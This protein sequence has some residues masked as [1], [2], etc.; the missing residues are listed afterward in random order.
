MKR[1][2]ERE[3]QINFIGSWIISNDKLFKNLIN[4]FEDNPQLHRQGVMGGGRN[5]NLDKKKTTEISIDPINLED[6]T[7]SIFYEYFNELFACYNDYKNQWPFL[8]E[9]LPVVDIP[10]FNLQRYLAGDHFSQV[11][12]ERISKS[13]MHRVFAWMTYL[14]DL[15]SNANGYTNFTHYDLKIKPLKGKTLIWPAEWT[16][17][18]AGETL[19]KGRKYIITGWFCFPFD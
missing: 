16:H 3:G 2:N 4:Y 10:S 18:H 5:I 9:K 6:K 15:E 11:H 17:A 7:H 8:K 19:I 12:T 13:N 14:N 1:I